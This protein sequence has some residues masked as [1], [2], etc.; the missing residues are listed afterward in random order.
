MNAPHYGSWFLSFQTL[1]KIHKG[2]VL[3]I[4]LHFFPIKEW[5]HPK[6]ASLTIVV[7]TQWIPNRSNNNYQRI[8]TFKQWR[9][10]WSMDSSSS[11]QRKHLLTKDHPLFWRWSIV[12]TFP[13]VASHAKKLT[14]DG[15]HKF[16]TT[17]FENEIK[18][19]S[20]NV[21]YKCLTENLLLLKFIHTILS[22]SAHLSLQPWK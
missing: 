17:L 2:V 16:Q 19:P 13:I 9:R 22:S 5:C 3:Q 21:A 11:L 15:T 10:V 20:S 18:T 7:C 14:L 4:M 12:K 8:L 6:R 1:Q